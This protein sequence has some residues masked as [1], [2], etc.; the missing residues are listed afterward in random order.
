M[1]QYLIMLCMYC[2]C[3][4]D[5]L[6]IVAAILAKSSPCSELYTI[7]EA[8]CFVC[9][10]FRQRPWVGDEPVRVGLGCVYMR[11]FNPGQISIRHVHKM[12]GAFT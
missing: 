9:R 4:F 12:N 10:P 1:L 11:R 5:L 8:Q 6:S 2:I 7:S 3:M